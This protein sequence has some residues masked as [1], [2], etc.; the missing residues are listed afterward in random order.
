MTDIPN[1]SR[2][3]PESA[4]QQQQ[5][6]K[7]RWLTIVVWLGIWLLCSLLLGHYASGGGETKETDSII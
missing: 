4:R 1:S 5:A 3:R 2:V 7:F 6:A